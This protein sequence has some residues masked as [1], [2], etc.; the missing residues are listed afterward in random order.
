VR[1]GTGFHD[2][3]APLQRGE[4]FEQLLSAH[5]PAE[6]GFTVPILSVKV[7]GVLAQINPNQRDFSHDGFST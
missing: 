1:A 6:H 4:E 5:L 7:K 3:G 2:R